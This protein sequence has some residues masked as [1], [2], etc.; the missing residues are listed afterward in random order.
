MRESKEYLKFFRASI[1]RLAVP[2]IIGVAVAIWYQSQ[3]PVSYIKTRLFESAFDENVDKKLLLIDQAVSTTRTPQV[4]SEL[5]GSGTRARVY[6][7]APLTLSLEVT[8]SNK[9]LLDSTLGGVSKYIILRYPLEIVGRDTESSKSPDLL[10]AAL[11]GAALGFSAGLAISLIKTYLH[12][13]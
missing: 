1:L 5:T 7:L 2:I 13:Y 6:K 8:S 4:L 3:T 9:E 12:R 10:L 11:F